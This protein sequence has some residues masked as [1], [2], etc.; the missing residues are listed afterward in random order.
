[1][2]IQALTTFTRFIRAVRTIRLRVAFPAHGDATA[3]SASKVGGWAGAYK[4]KNKRK[5]NSVYLMKINKFIH[6]IAEKLN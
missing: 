3:I 1:M 2:N 5:N 6:K 4:I